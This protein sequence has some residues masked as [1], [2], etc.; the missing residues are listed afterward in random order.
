MEN[1]PVGRVTQSSR[2]QKRQVPDLCFVPQTQVRA[3]ELALG[4][5]CSAVMAVGEGASVAGLATA[6]VHGAEDSG[7]PAGV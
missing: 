4:V 5:E 2:E 3:V 6:A 7:R 1:A